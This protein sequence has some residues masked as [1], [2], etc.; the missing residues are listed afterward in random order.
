MDKVGLLGQAYLVQ[1]K[2]FH[3]QFFVGSWKVPV[4]RQFQVAGAGP[5]VWLQQARSSGPGNY[6]GI[7]STQMAQL[8]HSRHA[9]RGVSV[10]G[11]ATTGAANIEA[12]QKVGLEVEKVVVGL[13]PTSQPVEGSSSLKDRQEKGVPSPKCPPPN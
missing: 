5:T 12:L 4:G 10:E 2:G 6:G 7:I 8:Q 13:P 3:G 1:V 9:N 11:T